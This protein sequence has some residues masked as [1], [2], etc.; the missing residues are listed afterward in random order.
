[1]IRP[2]QQNGVEI[3]KREHEDFCYCDLCIQTRVENFVEA[4]IEIE[5]M[6]ENGD[7]NP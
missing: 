6:E 2:V 1:M 5:K 7:E 4:Q 3:E